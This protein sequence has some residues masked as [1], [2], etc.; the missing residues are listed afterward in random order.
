[1]ATFLNLVNDLERESGT[2][3]K[4]SRLSTV[5]NAPARQEK[6]VEWVAEAWRLIQLDRSDWP[7]MRL[8]FEGP[9]VA[10]TARYSGASLGITNFSRWARPTWDYEPFTVYDS[11]IGR[12][13]EQRLHYIQWLAYKDRWDRGV[14][15][16]QRPTEVAVAPDGRLCVGATPEKG[17]RL[18]GEYFCTAQILNADT[19][20]PLCAEEHHNIIVWRALML[21]GDHD[22][23]P[24]TVATAKSKYDAS[25]RALV[26]ASMEMVTL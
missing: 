2:I 9:L 7:F 26:N 13:D 25:L 8:E 6:M 12:N 24:V 1:M 19:D 16:Y 17:Y 5:A 14:H 15:D 22:E 10:G 4:G 20:V 18:R 21:L 3:Q 23:S 11:A